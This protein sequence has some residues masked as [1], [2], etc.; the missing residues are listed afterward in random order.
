M[1]KFKLI[2]IALLLGILL[3][4]CSSD[5]NNEQQPEEDEATSE[6]SNENSEEVNDSNDENESEESDSKEVS[7][8]N[9]SDVLGLG[10]TGVVEST[11]GNYEI[12]FESFQVLNDLD[13]KKPNDADEVYILVEARVDNTGDQALN[14]TDLYTASLFTEDET[15]S[16][17][18]FHNE[19]IEFIDGTIEPGKSMEGQFL[20]SV[21]ES[22]SY[23]LI[24][25]HALGAFATELTWEFSADE[26][27]N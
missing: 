15:R 14:G 26:A 4:G 1:S 25:N 8:D 27:S 9:N 21:P 23:E 19:S 16:E 10:E 3:I 24:Y 12:T 11:I 18:D 2:T 22:N 20:F 5:G 13:G 7:A 6:R 17:N